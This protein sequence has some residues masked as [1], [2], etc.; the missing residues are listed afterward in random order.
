MLIGLLSDPHANLPAL[1]A[2]L[3]DVDHVRPDAL[4]CLGDFVG[5]GAQPNE[6]VD[7]LRDRCNVSLA[8]NHD[9]LALG[10]FDLE[11]VNTAAAAAIR[12]TSVRLTPSTMEFLEGLSA[13]GSFEGLELAHASL[14]D[15]VWEYVFDTWVAEQ[16]FKEHSF[17]VAVVGHTH[18][19]AVFW[20]SDGDV[21]GSRVSPP[22]G[23]GQAEFRIAEPRLMLNPGGIGQPRDGDPRASWATWETDT[24]AFT[25][26]RVNYPV[27][28]AQRAIR[29]AGLPESLAAR[30]SLGL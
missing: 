13:R 21:G 19:P 8:G 10:Q 18:V 7:A 4:V 28:E 24:R 27:E 23:A 15:P 6:V 25:L 30:L 26:R 3:A 1:E 14:R 16:N 9:L 17:A 12:W 2:V 29:G 11:M 20:L 22:P 5:Y